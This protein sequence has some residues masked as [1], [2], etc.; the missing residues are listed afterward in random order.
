VKSR[1]KAFGKDFNL[2]HS[3]IVIPDFCPVLGIPLS[4]NNNGAGYHSNSPSLDRIDNSKGYV[5][6]NV[7]VISAR[8]NLLKN[9]ATIEE[10]EL[11]LE[12]LR[13]CSGKSCSSSTHLMSS[14]RRNAS[15]LIATLLT[16]LSSTMA[17]VLTY[18][19]FIALLAVLV[20]LLLASL[21]LL[22]YL[23]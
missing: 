23:E 1:A 6:G 15:L 3:D 5:K 11:V 14:K 13:R 8:A 2:D 4:L 20:F 21:I 22:L 10:L 9:D 12:D 19:F 18:L 7:R 17:W 16:S